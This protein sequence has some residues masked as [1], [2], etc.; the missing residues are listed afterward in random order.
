MLKFVIIIFNCLC[1]GQIFGQDIRLTSGENFELNE[2]GEYKSQCSEELA[3]YEIGLLQIYLDTLPMGSE[4][5]KLLR[6]LAEKLT[7]K[8]RVF[9]I[10]SL[11]KHVYLQDAY[12]EKFIKTASVVQEM[13]NLAV[14]KAIKYFDE[15]EQY[16]R[17]F[18]DYLNHALMNKK[19]KPSLYSAIK[20]TLSSVKNFILI[21][22][23]VDKLFRNSNDQLEL[24]QPDIKS[25]IPK[26]YLTSIVCHE[27]S[28]HG[29]GVREFGFE[30]CLN[31]S[32]AGECYE[33][34]NDEFDALK[35]RLN[36]FLSDKCDL[37][38][39]DQFIESERISFLDDLKEYH[40]DIHSEGDEEKKSIRIEEKNYVI[41]KEVIKIKEKFI[42]I[43]QLWL[44]ICTENQLIRLKN[45]EVQELIQYRKGATGTSLYDHNFD[46]GCQIQF[47][48]KIF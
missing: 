4:R 23:F 13:D 22:S 37:L 16:A 9:D 47:S 17:Y 28:L 10:L 7:E 24:S 6:R 26:K 21:E 15:N 32:D 46:N 30:E 48:S 36:L 12:L 44:N 14:D 27:V 33:A 39:V 45:I 43:Q 3:T 20:K 2:C 5:N 38:T 8:G 42:H 35:N 19:V 31:K 40:Q 1:F 11:K 18:D 41:K 29:E 25:L 34:V